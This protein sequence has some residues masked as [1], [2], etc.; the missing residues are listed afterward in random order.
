MRVNGI[1][2]IVRRVVVMADIKG[3]KFP[4]PHLSHEHEQKKTGKIHLCNCSS[5]KRKVDEDDDS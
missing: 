1:I 2:P 4:L 3:I 5:V